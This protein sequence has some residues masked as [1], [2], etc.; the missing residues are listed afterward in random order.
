MRIKKMENLTLTQLHDIISHYLK[1]NPE[2]AKKY[3]A[4]YNEKIKNVE[5]L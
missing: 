3:I 4:L 5:V 2:Q 1:N